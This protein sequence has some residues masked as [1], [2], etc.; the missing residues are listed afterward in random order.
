MDR[1]DLPLVKQYAHGRWAGIVSALAGVD[2]DLL[3][4]QHHP[5]PRCGGT[6]RFRFTDLDSSGSALCNKC[7]K[8][9]DGFAF[10]EFMLGEKF[11]PVLAKVAGYLGIE[12]L[13]GKAGEHK[14][15]GKLPSNPAEHLEFKPWNEM[16]AAMWCIKKPPIIPA[17][18]LACG[19]RLACYRKR[20]H[21]V[22]LPIYGEKLTTGGPIG[23]TLYNRTGGMLPS[24]SRDAKTKK[25]N[26]TEE[27][28]LTTHGSK[29][30]LIGPV[31]QL[32]SATHVWKLEGPSDLLAFYS[33]AGIPPGVVAITNSAGAG[34]KPQ[35]WIIEM[36]AGKTVYV[37]HDADG[38]GQSGALGKTDARGTHRPGWLECV[39]ALA[40]ETNH[41]RLPYDVV[42]DH[43]KD[44][45][46]FLNEQEQCH[47]CKS[48]G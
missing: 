41:V 39:S 24:F 30:G 22:A 48:A 26:V 36:L 3:D 44:L 35:P 2:A 47:A 15:N 33:L 38:P 19:G 5:C 10:L 34:E 12:K 14:T 1:Y 21:V 40:S 7:G 42:P 25:W 37:L 9:G 46:D 27:K 16:A 23:W 20:Y 43:G 6:D 17:A 28:I 31:D 18:I 13:N 11:G 4:G 45:R 32:A 8:W 29:S